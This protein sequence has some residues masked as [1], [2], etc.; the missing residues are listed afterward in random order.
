MAKPLEDNNAPA[1]GLN[2]R[3]AGTAGNLNALPVGIIYISK[4]GR[5]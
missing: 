2:G 4:M 3:R 5:E 1:Y